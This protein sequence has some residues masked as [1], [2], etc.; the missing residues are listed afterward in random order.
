MKNNK[1]FNLPTE[2]EIDEYIENSNIETIEDLYNFLEVVGYAYQ[3]KPDKYAKHYVDALIQMGMYLKNYSLNSS[4]KAPQ[5]DEM[6][7]DALNMLNKA[8]NLAKKYYKTYPKE[9]QELYITVLNNLA[10]AYQDMND[11]ESAEKYYLQLIDI[12]E[13]NLSS[14][15]LEL[16]KFYIGTL[17][18]LSSLYFD[19][20]KIDKS[21]KILEKA[22]DFI[23]P[24]EKELE[25][26]EEL[27]FFYEKLKE[28]YN[29]LLEKEDDKVNIGINIGG[30]DIEMQTD[31]ESLKEAEE[32]M[33]SAF[34][35]NLSNL[36]TFKMYLNYMTGAIKKRLMKLLNANEGEKKEFASFVER[37][38]KNIYPYRN[39]FL[40]T[41]GIE[42][43]LIYHLE[44]L[45]TL[46]EDIKD[47]KAQKI[48][49]Q[50]Q[51]LKK[52][53]KG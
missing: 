1:N 3:F 24:L 52:E 39:K 53:I 14:K 16:I 42:N 6:F 51:K 36:D 34:E 19:L 44:L 37:F 26:D 31:E 7:Q 15:D 22:L 4:I 50:I 29:F 2:K 9:W 5:E 35:S 41:E 47:E 11:F 12:I 10:S 46:Y 23:K 43:I 32:E 21:K 27:M 18:N 48:K 8:V 49:K 45:Q 25:K 28:N 30:I 20:G 40:S 13:K 38:V 17:N 33:I